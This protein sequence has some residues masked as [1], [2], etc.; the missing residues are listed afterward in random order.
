[1]RKLGE[2]TALCQELKICEE[3]LLF[4]LSWAGVYNMNVCKIEHDSVSYQ[5]SLI[6]LLLFGE[7]GVHVFV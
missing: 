2:S 7:G 5:F 6:N 3:Y 1:M 4:V